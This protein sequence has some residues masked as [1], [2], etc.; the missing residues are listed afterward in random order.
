MRIC[1][2]AEAISVH[3]QKWVRYFVEKGNDILVL[4]HEEAPIPGAQVLP[5]LRVTR[6][7]WLLRKLEVLR[8]TWRFWSIVRAFAPDIVH[9]HCIDESLTN[10]LWYW[11]MKDLFVSTWG[12]DVVDGYLI[13]RKRSSF[14]RR[15]LL[16]QAQVVTATSHFLADVTRH[17]TD[18][19][20]H[21]VPFGVDCQVFRPPE[22]IKTSSTV[23][24][25]FVKH[26]K[27]KYGAEYLIRAMSS[28]VDQHPQTRLLMVGSGELRSQL[29]DLTRQLGLTRNISFLGAIEHRQVPE[30]L[31]NVD[32]FVMPSVREEF[33]VAAVE[34]QAMGIP[35]VS[36]RVGGIPEAVL[37]GETGIL[38]EPGDSEQLAQAIVTLI[39]DPVLRRQM[40]ERG[41]R[42]VLANYRWEDNAA[43][44]ERLYHSFVH[45]SRK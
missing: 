14:Y 7:N 35:V 8:N 29:E 6:S 21:V 32:I 36:T 15:F 42:H 38:V 11:G 20:I 33:G 40:G 34:A 30:I 10:L 12:S 25:G 22:R 39:E 19:E 26:L 27:V 1:F 9:V 37:D 28:I 23:T 5:A 43:L 31:K 41:R 13:G 18:K 4:C 17:Y 45:P 2:V 16:R 24:L 3:T 44:M